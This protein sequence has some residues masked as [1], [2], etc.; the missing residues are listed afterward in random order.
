MD[1]PSLPVS[2]LLPHLNL[3]EPQ[4]THREEEAASSE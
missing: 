3:P 4:V 1:P 2:H